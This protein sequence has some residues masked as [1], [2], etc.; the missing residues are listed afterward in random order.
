MPRLMGMPIDSVTLAEAADRV[1]DSAAG[2]Q[3]GTIITPNID[4]LRQ[5]RKSPRLRREF[6]GITLRV[7]DGM[8][9]VLALR[10][11][12]TPVTGQITGTDLLWAIAAAAAT[13]GCSL[14]LAGGQP[15][16]AERAADRL[17]Q[18]H[19]GL[20]A[21]ARP[22]YVL[23]HSEADEIAA[24]A[25]ALSAAQPD[26]VFLGVPFRTQIAAMAALR[27]ELPST[28]FVGVGSSF[29]LVNGDRT[30][31][32]RWVQRACLEWA[33]RLTQQPHLWRRYLV[34]GMPIAVLL[35]LSALRERWRRTPEQTTQLAARRR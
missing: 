19:P 32:P 15:G 12:R 28:W 16:D 3:G 30:R 35:V 5:Y 20:V 1:V 22:C 21:N 2:G 17:R 11:Q 33:W 7:A 13:R 34:D 25:A 29:E 9:L 24:L 14:M 27:T 31:P 26:V 4:I 10:L 18:T 23:P 6:E 8:P